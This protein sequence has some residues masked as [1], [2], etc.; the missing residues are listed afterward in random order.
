MISGCYLLIPCLGFLVPAILAFIIN[1]VAL[2]F[3]I[4]YIFRQ[5]HREKP[6]HFFNNKYVEKNRNVSE[7]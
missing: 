3:F 2:G 1:V 7:L 5:I 4:L 6:A